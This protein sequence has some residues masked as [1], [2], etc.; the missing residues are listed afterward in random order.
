LKGA[1][2]IRKA[3]DANMPTYLY[4]KQFVLQVTPKH[5]GYDP[6]DD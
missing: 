6:R 1:N 3:V 4:L 5:H 2:I